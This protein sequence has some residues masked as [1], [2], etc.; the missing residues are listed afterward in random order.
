MRPL[1][2]RRFGRLLRRLLAS[3]LCLFLVVDLY[4][5]WRAQNPYDPSWL[6][7]RDSK[8]LRVGLDPTY[9]PFSAFSADGSQVF[10]LDVDLANALAERLGARAQ[11]VPLGIDGLY[12]ALQTGQVDVLISALSVDPGQ[13]DKVA[14]FAP[15]LDAGVMLVSR[16]DDTYPT[17]NTLDGKHIAVE[18]GSP[19]D[20]EARRWTR[21][22]K[23][24]TVERLIQ[25]EQALDAVANG[26]VD[27]ALIDQVTLRLYQR[28]NPQNQL[29][30]AEKPVF[31]DP[32]VMAT[33]LSAR[34]LTRRLNDVF[35]A[36][37]AD[38]TLAKLIDRW[39]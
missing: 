36:L 13:W 14:Y 5:Y 15:Y 10:G 6:Y 9:P 24:L 28:R 19:G 4:F 17:M 18:F 23:A 11:F 1:S 20:E 33:R 30:M 26:K 21:R 22:L 3:A 38:G 34:D 35:L 8:V 2:K 7:V 31:S 25:P 37:A 39:L 29:V 27:A 16:R 32:Y 12:S